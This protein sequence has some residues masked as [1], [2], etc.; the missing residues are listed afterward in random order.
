M[1]FTFLPLKLIQDKRVF[2]D[3]PFLICNQFS[4]ME[5]VW[6]KF[7]CYFQSPYCLQ[8]ITVIHLD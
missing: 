2:N 6:I 4:K 1:F 8:Q 3:F 7:K 5:A